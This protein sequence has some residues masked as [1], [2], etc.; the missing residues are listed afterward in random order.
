MMEVTKVI[1]TR[2]YEF[3][4]KVYMRGATMFVSS[5]FRDAGS[6]VDKYKVLN[7][8]GEYIC[9]IFSS[10]HNFAGGTLFKASAAPK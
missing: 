4:N 6:T 8:D 3:A 5:S 7:E 9:S 2:D 1:L 10:L